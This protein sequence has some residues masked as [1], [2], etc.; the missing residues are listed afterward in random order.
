LA[1]LVQDGET[2][3]TVPAGDPQALADKLRALIIDQELRHRLGEQAA[4]FAQVYDWHLIA[5]Q[6]VDLY[7][8]VIDNS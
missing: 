6:I 7:R 5:E 3:Y 2:G 8:D 4:A 1:F